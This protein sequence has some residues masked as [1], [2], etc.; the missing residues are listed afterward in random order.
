[1]SDV[2][3]GK[4]VAITGRMASMTRRE[5]G[6]LIRERGGELSGSVSRRTDVLVVGQEG[7]PLAADGNLTV[8]LRRAREI[9]AGGGAVR[10][11]SED[12]FLRELGLAERREAARRL[13]TTAQLGRMLGVPGHRIRAWVRKGL[14]T[15]VKTVHRLAYFDFPQVAA[16]K[17]VADLVES[18]IAPERIRKS[19]E[20][21]SRWLPGTEAPF[22]QIR[23]LAEG[24]EL[25]VRREDGRLSDAQGQLQLDFEPP[26]PADTVTPPARSADD[27][28]EDGL[29]RE[30]AGDF[31]G[32]AGA[33][34]KA[35]SSG[36]PE[37]E[38]CLNLGNVLYHLGRM[39]E[40]LARYRQAAELDSEYVEAW[41]NLGNVL[42]ER[43]EW[44]AAVRAFE[45]AIAVE[46]LY[47][48]AHYNFAET[49][50]QMGRTDAARR[51]WRAYLAQDPDSSWAEHVR[52][53]LDES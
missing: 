45:R 41:N 46:P 43:G 44:D 28:F 7:W 8:K 14:L 5:A 52:N 3:D 4:H 23:I 20:D 24:G 36:G 1:M 19:L 47:A 50:H 2:L 42:S 49:L 37:P 22:H 12:E 33:Y 35:L 34:E 10:I 6:E 17:A 18:G 13:F 16:A 25:L 32:A 21:L 15:P 40:A 30:D 27:W 26:R 38:V 31:E 29:D 51:H 39:E 9:E 11:L 48:D 53:R